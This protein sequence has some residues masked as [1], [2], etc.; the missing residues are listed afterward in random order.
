M[1][2]R[3]AEITDIPNIA[4]LRALEWGDPQYW[5]P[6]VSGYLSGKQNPQQA[7]KPRTC[8]V[9]IDQGSL[10]G[11]IAGHLTRRYDCDGELQWINVAP[12][13]RGGGVASALLR[14][15]AAWFTTQNAR[16]ICV[17]VEP[18]N[19]MARAFYTRHG[20]QNLNDHWLLWTDIGIALRE[21]PKPERFPRR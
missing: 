6:R 5:E 18:D 21:D 8:H 2:Y 16:R 19:A 13:H 12:E 17:D 10:V 1:L 7:L 20:A 4:R 15:I 9:A 14:L 3:P 11:F